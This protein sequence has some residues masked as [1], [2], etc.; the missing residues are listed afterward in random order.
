M[1]RA[2]RQ[3]SRHRQ[4][5]S[6]PQMQQMQ[7]AQQAAGGRQGGRQEQAGSRSKQEYARIM[8]NK[9]RTSRK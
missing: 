8:R 2:G 7:Q 6:R 4:V 9:Q 1:Y 3:A 5:G